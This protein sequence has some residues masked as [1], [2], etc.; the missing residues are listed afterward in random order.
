MPEIVVVT[1]GWSEEGLGA[2]CR[3]EVAALEGADIFLGCPVGV[4]LV[5][6]SY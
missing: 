5:Y 4:R 6:Y 3:I 1:I 2:V